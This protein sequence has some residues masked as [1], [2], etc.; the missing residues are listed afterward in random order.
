MTIWKRVWNYI[1]NMSTADA[2][3]SKTSNAAVMSMRKMSIVAVMSMK[4]MSIADAARMRSPAA[5][6]MITAAAVTTARK[7][8]RSCL[9]VS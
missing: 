6:A 2:N 5:P 4:R 9:R 7:T 8:A 1:K 3:M